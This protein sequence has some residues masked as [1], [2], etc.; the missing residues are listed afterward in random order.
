MLCFLDSGTIS[1]R[2]YW[3]ATTIQSAPLPARFYH[4]TVGLILDRRKICSGYSSV[5]RL[6]EIGSEL[7]HYLVAALGVV[8]GYLG[9]TTVS[10]MRL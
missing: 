9:V 10:I 5:K 8:R 3:S 4:V 6:F 7:R 1:A 2:D